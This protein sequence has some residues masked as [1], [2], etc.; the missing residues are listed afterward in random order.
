MSSPSWLRNR[1]S[2]M[3]ALGALVLICAV[4]ASTLQ[5]TVADRRPV[6]EG[7]DFK[8]VPSRTAN[9]DYREKL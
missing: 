2:Y 1:A 8:T 7:L 6:L 3:L 4:D 5:R 9:F